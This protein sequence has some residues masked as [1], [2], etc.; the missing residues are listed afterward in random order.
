[1]IISL[2]RWIQAVGGDMGQRERERRATKTV[3]EKTLA[4]LQVSDDSFQN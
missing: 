1:M 3:P 4:L 2:N